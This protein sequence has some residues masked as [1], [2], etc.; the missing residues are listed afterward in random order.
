MTY[1]PDD[2]TRLVRTKITVCDFCGCWVWDGGCDTSGYA[3]FKLRGKTLILHRYTYEQLVGEIPEGMTIDHLNCTLR[4]CIN[5]NHMQVVSALDNTLR[6]NATRW[7]DVKFDDQGQPI[8]RSKCP[9]CVDRGE[10]LRV[11][12]LSATGA[13]LNNVAE[14]RAVA[15]LFN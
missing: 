3:K 12:N 9:D 13:H 1:Q 11:G 8:A 7:H 10:R 4:R 6:A 5:P 14:A 15:E 2:L